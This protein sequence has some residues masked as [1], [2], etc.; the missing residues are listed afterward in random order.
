M[1]AR[2]PTRIVIVGG[3]FGGVYTALELQRLLRRDRDVEVTIVSRDNFLLFTPML[4]EVAASDLDVTHIVNPVRKLLPRVRFF[5]GDVTT[6]DLRRRAVVVAHGADSHT[7]DLPYDHLVVALGSVTNFFGIPGLEERAL[8]MKSLGDAIALRNRMIALLE[9][10]DTECC[11]AARTRLLTFVVAGAGFAGLETVAAM[12]D[13]VREAVRFYPRIT[14]EMVRM[15]LVHPEEVVLP[16]LSPSLGR[17]AQRKL[18]ARG[19]EVHGRTKV[20]AIADA[21]VALSDGTIVPASTV[22]WTAGT[23][24]S[25]LV[26]TLPCNR[27]RG[28]ICVNDRLQVDGWAGVWALGDCALVPD[29]A[30]GRFHPP[31][32][33]HAIRQGRCAARNIVASLRGQ[34]LRPFAFRTI[35]QLASLGR[36]TGVAQIL[37]V[38]FSGFIAWWL[39]RTIYLAKLP[40]LEKK[41]RVA[42]DWTLDL[43][44][45]KD[46]VK[47]VTA[48]GATV[49]RPTPRQDEASF[50]S[51]TSAAPV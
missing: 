34:P 12:N 40:R 48:T 15:V 46:L 28:R 36:R 8:T 17:Y 32:A 50:P 27:Q 18:E 1:S 47:F 30:T 7:H 33:Q 38:N 39:W 14:P 13:F 51:V 19:V 23:T 16:E 21:A 49:S 20:T 10:A 24:P 22:V 35:G 11:A 31:T 3:G 43:V 42:L 26:A 4:H 9:E 41:V 6:I 29:G 44:F 45:S 5:D 2:T 25:P 37:G